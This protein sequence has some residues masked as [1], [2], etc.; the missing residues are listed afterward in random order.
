[1]SPAS[2]SAC[3]AGE[4]RRHSVARSTSGCGVPDPGAGRIG[5]QRRHVV[6]RDLVDSA[7][8]ARTTATARRRRRQRAERRLERRRRL[9]GQIAGGMQPALPR[10]AQPV[11]RR[12]DLGERRAR[13]RSRP[14]RDTAAPAPR[15]ARASSSSTKGRSRRHHARRRCSRARRQRQAHACRLS[16]ASPRSRR[17]TDA[18]PAAARRD[19]PRH[20]APAELH[21]CSGAPQTM[22]GAFVD[23]GGD[24]PQLQGGGGAA[25]RHDRE[26]PPHARPYRSLRRG[27]A[28]SPRSSACR[29]RGRTRTIASGSRGSSEDGAQYG[30]AGALVRARPLAGR[31]RPGDGRRADARRLPLP[32]PHAGPCRLPPRADRSWR[33]SATCCSRD[34]SAAPISRAAITSDLIDSIVTK[35]WPLGDDTVFVPGHGQPSTFAHERRTNPFVGDA[36][37]AAEPM[38][39]GRHPNRHRRLD[40][41]AVARDLLSREMAAEA[42][43]RICRRAS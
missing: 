5:Q 21:A 13:R 18:Q 36:A 32:R 33:S 29:S 40:L 34:R 43:A 42:R 4:L 22:R 17:M 23:P 35:L 16:R 38:K 37:L 31:G 8:T 30:V 28:R 39:H 11:E 2:I 41:R 6:G 12:R 20:A 9:I 7:R 27:R 25:W 3:D 24:L 19:H 10:R 1:M 14:D 26:D 15:R